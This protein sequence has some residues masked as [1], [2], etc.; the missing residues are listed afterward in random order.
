MRLFAYTCLKGAFILSLFCFACEPAP[1]EPQGKP[2]AQFGDYMLT[3]EE[4]ASML[5]EGLN[6]QDSLRQANAYIQ[7]W[8]KQ[9]AIMAAAVKAVPGLSEKL[10]YEA[11]AQ[12][13]TM[14][15]YH[16][17]EHLSKST[18][19]AKISL[20]E[21]REY[22]RKHSDKFIAERNYYAYFHLRTEKRPPNKQVALMRSDDLADIASLKAWGKTESAVMKL[23][24]IFVGE[25]ALTAILEGSYLRVQNLRIGRTQTFRNQVDGKPYQHIL[26]LVGKVEAGKPMP[27]RM[28]M[29]HISEIILTQRKNQLIR[30]SEAQQLQKAQKEGKAR[31]F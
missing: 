2:V 23:D 8:L 26:K 24:S 9:Q 5:P 11:E 27:L 13:R 19:N 6:K 28:C 12:R 1:G 17:G 4:I 7:S 18:L 16:Y 10:N 15:A 3:A 31:V 30:Q 22:Y 25:S 20:A 21:A 29:P 14:A